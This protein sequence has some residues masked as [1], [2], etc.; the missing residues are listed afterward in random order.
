MKIFQ[1][2]QLKD[3]E[4]WS[5]AVGRANQLTD[6]QFAMVE[7]VLEEEHP[8]GME[9]M[10]IN[11][12]FWFGF[13]WVANVAGLYPKYFKITS[14]CGYSKYVTAHSMDDVD[15]LESSGVEFDEVSTVTCLDD[16]VEDINLDDFNNTH[17]YEVFSRHLGERMVVRCEGDEA[18]K[19]FK[20][21]FSMCKMNEIE[22][23]PEDGFDD[24]EDSE[25]WNMFEDIREFAYD[26]INAETYEF[27]IPT[28]A[29]NEVCRLILDPNDSL[30]YYEVPESFALNVRNN[31][32]ELNDEDL[33]NIKEFVSMLNKLMP[34]GFTID[35]DVESVGSPEFR[36]D[37]E[38]GLAM[39]CVKMYAY[40][41]AADK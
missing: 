27:W 13:E 7:Q 10:E 39:D 35:W 34:N 14:K 3:F 9:D 12:L 40:K 17:Y 38:F 19:K 5:G 20:D 36:T 33:K 25:D 41:K 8:D 37:P 32:I 18:A 30:D 22:S 11:D 15:A 23:V 1:E 21:Q 26:I 29:V 28:Y 24:E 31:G 16:D 4:F 2:I 6:E